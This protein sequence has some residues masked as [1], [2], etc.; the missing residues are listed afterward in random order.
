[1]L[2]NR[3]WLGA[4]MHTAHPHYSPCGRGTNARLKAIPVTPTRI[5]RNCSRLG[6]RWRSR[7][8]LAVTVNSEVWI[9]Y[10]RDSQTFLVADSGFPF[11]HIEPLIASI[12]YLSAQEGTVKWLGVSAESCSNQ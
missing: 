10:E 2:R 12:F 9:E 3:L 5:S 6:L 8:S 1:M 11:I 4:A 7:Q